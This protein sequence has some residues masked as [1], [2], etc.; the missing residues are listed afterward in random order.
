VLMV[1]FMQQGT[2]ITSEAYCKTPKKVRR[3]VVMLTCGVV[4]LHE[5]APLH[6]AACTRALLEHLKWELFD[7]PPYSPDTATTTSLPIWR[8]GWDHSTSAVIRSWWKVW[9]CGWAHKQQTSLTQ[10]YGNLFPDTTGASVVVTM[11]RSSLNMYI[12][13]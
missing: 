4:L 11:M 7:H 12:W 3:A 1:E 2:T 8:T 6:T 5:N 13:P 9:K 10:A